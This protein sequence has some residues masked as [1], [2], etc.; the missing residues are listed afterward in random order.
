MRINASHLAQSGS[1][2]N[3]QAGIDREHILADDRE[4]RGVVDKR[5]DYLVDSA[6][7]RVFNWRDRSFSES[8]LNRANDIVNGR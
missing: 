7:D 5:V 2:A 8:F 6:F 4:V 1:L 3:D